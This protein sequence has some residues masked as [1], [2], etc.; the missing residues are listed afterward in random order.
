MMMMRIF[1]KLTMLSILS[2]VSLTFV[3]SFLRI[4][5]TIYVNNHGLD[6]RIIIIIT[7]IHVITI[8]FY[9]IK[10]ITKKTLIM[11]ILNTSIFL[12]IG[13][14]LRNINIVITKDKYIYIWII[15]SVLIF[16]IGLIILYIYNKKYIINNKFIDKLKSIKID[17]RFWF[18]VAKLIGAF[19][20]K[21]FILML[22]I[23]YDL[24]SIIINKK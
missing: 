20:I 22:I 8:I 3:L 7:I 9:K 15:T 6:L 17:N 11:V 16:I 12:I 1:N 19:I 21:M 23:K 4:Y 24:L 5:I 10:Y 14:L 2:W 18:Y 13:I